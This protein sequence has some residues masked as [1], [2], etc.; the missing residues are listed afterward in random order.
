MFHITH[1]IHN[2]I[3]FVFPNLNSKNDRIAVIIRPFSSG[4]SKWE[5]ALEQ[6]FSLANRVESGTQAHDF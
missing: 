1:N 3:R 6:H 4:F 5:Y 2:Y